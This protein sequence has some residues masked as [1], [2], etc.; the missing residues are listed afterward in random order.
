MPKVARKGYESGTDTPYW[1]LKGM[2]DSYRPA[3]IRGKLTVRDLPEHMV[4]EDEAQRTFTL[5]VMQDHYHPSTPYH[6]AGKQVYHGPSVDKLQE[7]IA[8][9]FMVSQIEYGNST[10]TRDHL[11]NMLTEKR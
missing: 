8:E 10:A 4:D 1:I 6:S 3:P 5:E 11:I 7:A 9:T 2:G